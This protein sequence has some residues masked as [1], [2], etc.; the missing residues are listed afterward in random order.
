MAKIAI[1]KTEYEN[2]PDYNPGGGFKI[3]PCEVGV[4]FEIYGRTE[5]KEWEG[6]FIAKDGEKHS[7]ISIPCTFELTDDDGNVQRYDH[8]EFFDLDDPQGLAKLKEFV[9]NIGMIEVL[10]EDFDT[11]MLKGVVFFAD[12]EHWQDKQNKTKASMGIKSIA[13]PEDDGETE[14][15]PEEKPVEKAKGKPKQPPRGGRG[16]R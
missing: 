4:P 5:S 12:V 16:V 10:N 13:L 6:T 11:K 8:G 14:E 15:E 7:A 3:P 1:P 9:M 2:L